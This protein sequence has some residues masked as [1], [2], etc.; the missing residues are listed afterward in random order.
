M[1]FG[2]RVLRT[3]LSHV[4][5]NPRYSAPYDHNARPSQT[6]KQTD[7]QTIGQKSWQ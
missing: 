4:N 3:E 1:C 7:G 2:V 6:D 5:L